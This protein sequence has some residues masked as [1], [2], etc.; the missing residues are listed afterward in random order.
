M[1]D[2]SKENIVEGLSSAAVSAVAA[3][4]AGGGGA[5]DDYEVL[6]RRITCHPLYG[7]LIETHLDCLKGSMGDIEGF[8]RNSP[9]QANNNVSNTT[10]PAC[11]DLDHF[12]V[13]MYSLHL[14]ISSSVHLCSLIN[15]SL[16]NRKLSRA[17]E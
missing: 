4:T 15:S 13:Y 2:N 16:Q 1:E 11:S 3:A 9:N 5:R 7:L 10:I 12:M 17:T 8:Q 14:F 6:K